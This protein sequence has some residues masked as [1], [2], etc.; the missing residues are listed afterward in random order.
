MGQCGGSAL[1]SWFGSILVSV[2]VLIPVD[3]YCLCVYRVVSFILLFY[4]KDVLDFLGL[5]H[6]IQILESDCQ[7]AFLRTCWDFD[8]FSVN[9]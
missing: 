2:L 8:L 9:F 7:F 4:L 3:L 6:L 1:F 5:L